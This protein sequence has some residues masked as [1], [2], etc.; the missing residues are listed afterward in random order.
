MRRIIL[1]GIVALAAAASLF[2]ACSGDDNSVGGGGTDGG[3]D[4]TSGD[5]G[6]VDTGAGDTGSTDAGD[7]AVT[8]AGDAGPSY[9][10]LSYSS[11][12]YSKT[13]FTAYRIGDFSTAGVFEYS[14]YGTQA[15]GAT[16]PWVLEGANDRVHQMDPVEPWKVVSTWNVATPKTSDGGVPFSNPSGVAEVGGKAYVTLFDRNLIAVLDLATVSDGGAPT[17]L[18]DVSKW[19]QAADGD[20]HVDMSDILYVPSQKRLYVLLGNIDLGKV[21]P[22]GFFLLC[23]GARAAVGAIDVTTDTIVDLGTPSVAAGALPLD[24]VSPLALTYDAKNDRILVVHAGC[25]EPPAADAGADAGAG[26]LRGR[27]IEEVKLAAKTTK[28]LLDANAM[29]YPGRLVYVDETHAFMTFSGTTY[30]WNPTS[31]ALGAKAPTSPDYFTYDGKGALLGPKVALL[32]D[33]GV[34]SVDL[35]SVRTDTGVAKVVRGGA[36][37]KTFDYF[38]AISIWPQP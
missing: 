19:Q 13:S 26:P 8:E 24:G 33:G 3:K 34:S 9:L 31:P 14:A 5:T 29:P 20:G 6:T 30:A 12:G 36:V 15:N 7:A 21:D 1:S 38:E 25:N 4:A 10:M 28:I 37:P 2:T 35:L 27:V 17:K 11:E 32:A 18:I 16:S 22:Q 23:S